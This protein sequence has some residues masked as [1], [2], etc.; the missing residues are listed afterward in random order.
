MH[1]RRRS[2]VRSVDVPV[3]RVGL[4]SSGV[5]RCCVPLQAVRRAGGGS[6]HGPARQ[7]RRS[8]AG[9]RCSRQAGPGWSRRR[10]D[11]GPVRGRLALC[12]V[13]LSELADN[14]SGRVNVAWSLARQRTAIAGSYVIGGKVLWFTGLV[15]LWYFVAC[16]WR[17]SPGRRP[18]LVASIAGVISHFLPMVLRYYEHY[19]VLPLPFLV[20]SMTV[21]EPDPVRTRPE[22]VK[23]RF[24]FVVVLAILGLGAYS[25]VRVA[26]LADEAQRQA[27]MTSAVRALLP[28][29]SRVYLS[30]HRYLYVTA[31][32]R[33]GLPTSAIPSFLSRRRYDTQSRR[34]SR[35]APR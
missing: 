24:V 17:V 29:G 15:V 4:R 16:V 19:F 5:R 7:P 12:G 21:L 32:L 18:V 11:P 25:L 33:N 14:L 30:A 8:V 23:R 3:A 34:S 26:R 31:E 35:P 28:A 9:S 27:E 10:H 20:L 1:A 22:V 6:H 13:D 2:G